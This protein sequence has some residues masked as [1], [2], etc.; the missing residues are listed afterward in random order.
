MR[1]KNDTAIS[2][3]DVLSDT[4]F[5]NFI[6]DNSDSFVGTTLQQRYQEMCG[7]TPD[8]YNPAIEYEEVDLTDIGYNYAMFEV[9]LP[10]GVPLDHFHL[11]LQ[12]ANRAWSEMGK[13]RSQFINPDNEPF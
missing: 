4:W 6:N 2:K 3:D 5:D 8:T 11:M 10:L 9:P 13:D 7:G 12:G 1:S